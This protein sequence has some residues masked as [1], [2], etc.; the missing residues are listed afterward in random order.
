[1]KQ[2]YI[3]SS[4]FLDQGKGTPVEWILAGV[5]HCRWITISQ[6]EEQMI[7]FAKTDKED[8]P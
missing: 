3:L 7:F 1:M 8:T 6:F 5:D 2:Q 4:W